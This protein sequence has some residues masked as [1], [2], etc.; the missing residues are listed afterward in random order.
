MRVC[1]LRLHCRAAPIRERGSDRP[2]RDLGLDMI[3]PTRRPKEKADA[4]PGTETREPHEWEAEPQ[5]AGPG[6]RS[7]RMRRDRLRLVVTRL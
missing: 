5:A 6:G 3:E 7:P 1:G 2:V 4:S